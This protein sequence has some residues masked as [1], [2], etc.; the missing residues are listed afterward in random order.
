MVCARCAMTAAV[1]SM[2]IAPCTPSTS[3]RPWRIGSS[4][5]TLSAP[6]RRFELLLEPPDRFGAIHV[7]TED[8]LLVDRDHARALGTRDRDALELPEPERIAASGDR[9]DR[10][11]MHGA[12]RFAV[13]IAARFEQRARIIGH[14]DG[15]DLR[16]LCD[17]GLRNQGELRHA[18]AFQAQRVNRGNN[19]P[20]CAWCT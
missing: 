2:T 3:R 19:K 14:H 11:D 7:D 4:I 1:W 6:K 12:E 5:A 15:G 17:L 10:G 8:F 16:E 9:L 13:D 20:A 18:S